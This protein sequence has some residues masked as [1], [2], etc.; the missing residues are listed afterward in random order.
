MPVPAFI[1]AE[2]GEREGRELGKGEA[3]DGGREGRRKRE[4]RELRE[5][6]EEAE[7]RDGGRGSDFAGTGSGWKMAAAASIAR[8][9]WMI[10]WESLAN[11]FPSLIFSLYFFS[12]SFLLLVSIFLLW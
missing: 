10:D 8:S 7:A 11:I 3:K 9:G 1:H 2:K 5:G 12:I 4:E 6:E